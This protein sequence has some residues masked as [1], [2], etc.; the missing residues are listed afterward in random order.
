MSSSLDD[1]SSFHNSGMEGEVTH[2]VC[3]IYQYK[4]KKEKKILLVVGLFVIVI[5]FIG[6]LLLLLLLWYLVHFFVYSLSLSH[7]FYR[8]LLMMQTG[9]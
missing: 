3:V 8:F 9:E 2:W 7:I 4:K 6:C 5:F 1:T